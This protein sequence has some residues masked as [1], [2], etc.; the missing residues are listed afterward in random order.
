MC[1]TGEVDQINGGRRKGRP[2]IRREDSIREWTELPLASSLRL[3]ED[4]IRCLEV[5]I[6]S[7]VMPHPAPSSAAGEDAELKLMICLSPFPFSFAS[8]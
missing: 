6:H 5:V 1:E 2:S 8:S 7:S 3:V 4:S